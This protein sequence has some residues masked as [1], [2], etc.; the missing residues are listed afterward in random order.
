[1][2]TSWT[3]RSD[4]HL[5]DTRLCDLGLT[6]NGSKMQKEL[7]VLWDELA[8]RGFAFRPHCWLSDCWFLMPA[9]NPSGS[10]K[11]LVGWNCGMGHST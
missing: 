1:M 7:E 3:R 9:Q 5:L 6:L 4:E 10:K 8:H 11:L 2:T